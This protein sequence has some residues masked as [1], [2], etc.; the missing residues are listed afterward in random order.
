[1][2]R[3]DNYRQNTM[4]KQHFLAPGFCLGCDLQARVAVAACGQRCGQPW[5]AGMID[6]RVRATLDAMYRTYPN[7]RQLAR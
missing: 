6:A 5:A 2:N 1:M 4:T 3:I 7:T